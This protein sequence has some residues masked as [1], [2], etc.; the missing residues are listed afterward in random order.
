MRVRS[1]FTGKV[2]RAEPVVK[3]TTSKRPKLEYLLFKDGR[4][5]VVDPWPY[6]ILRE[7]EEAEE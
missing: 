3:R 6:E 5:E 1:L 4:A 7:D 2:Y